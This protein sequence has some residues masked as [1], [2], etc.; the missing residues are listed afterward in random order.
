MAI[1]KRANLLIPYSSSIKAGTE[2]H[3][4]TYSSRIGKRR[5]NNSFDP[6]C[7]RL[8]LLFVENGNTTSLIYSSRRPIWSRDEPA[9]DALGHLVSVSVV[10]GARN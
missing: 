4:Q 5:N 10:A 3:R 7:P 8:R 2:M 1:V 6:G 9:R